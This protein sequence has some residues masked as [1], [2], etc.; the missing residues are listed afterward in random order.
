MCESFKLTDTRRRGALNTR[1]TSTMYATGSELNLCV[2]P[3]AVDAQARVLQ[4][5]GTFKAV[6]LGRVDN[7]T[8][9]VPLH[10]T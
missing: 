8:Q 3:C 5:S 7:G 1:D 9:A 10:L 2:G 6:P 4:Y